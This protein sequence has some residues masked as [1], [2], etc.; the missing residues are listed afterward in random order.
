MSK[1]ILLIRLRLLG[2][3]ILTIPTIKLLKKNY[4][5]HNIYYIVEEEF[6]EIGNLLPDIYKLIVIPRKMGLKDMLNLRKKLKKLKFEF[7]ID[8]HSGPKSSQISFLSGIKEK[9]GYK[10]PFRS[11]IY[12]KAI[13][14]AQ[15]KP[16]THSVLN[17]IRLL[18]GLKIMPDKDDIPCYPQIRINEEDIINIELKKLSKDKR[19]IVHIGAGNDFRDW[20]KDKFIDLS[21]KLI[22]K[23]IEVCL[24]GHGDIENKRG[25]EISEKTGAINFAG[26]LSIHETLFLIQESEVYFGVDSGPM[27]LASL[28]ET[29]IVAVFGPNVP[30]ISGPWRK[31]SITILQSDLNCRPCDQRECIYK[32]NNDRIKC[33]KDIGV[34]YAYEEII[35]YIG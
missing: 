26:D 6:E 4:P 8:L 23:G 22:K 9:I 10:V 17:Q 24:I 11:W 16:L 12:D 3:I 2:D 1:N 21:E 30:E 35:K 27:H 29:P 31:S 13:D 14:R 18:E 33:M 5:K 7:L 34:N 25:K 28:S 19:V 15:K 32:A 20:G